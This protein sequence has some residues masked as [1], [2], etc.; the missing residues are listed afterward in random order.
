MDRNTIINDRDQLIEW[1]IEACKPKNKWMVGTEH[2]KFAYTFSKQKKRYIPLEYFGSYGIKTFLTELSKHGWMPIYEEKNIIALKKK[3]QSITLEPGGQI[4]LSGAPLKNLHSTCRETNEH[5]KLLKEVGS[6]LGILLVGLGVRPNETLQEVP[7]MPKARYKIMRGYMPTRGSR[8]L[9]MMHSTCTVQANLDF[10]SEEDMIK[11]TRL[12]V[13]L[14]PVVT[15][16]FANSPFYRGDF[17]GYES[18]RK[19]IWTDTDPDRCG[20]LKIALEDNFSFSQ[21]VNYA[22]SVPMYF[23]VR[24]NNYLNCAGKSF[25]E[26]MRGKLDVIPDEKPTIADWE[27]HLS[28]I[29]TEVR[30]KKIIEVRGADAGNWRRTCALPAFWVGILYGN[31]SINLAEKI[32]ENWT[33][34]DIEQLSVDVAKLGL[35]AEIKK[36][37]VFYIASELLNIARNTLLERG[38]LDS[39]GNDETGYLNV[40]EEILQNKASPARDLINNFSSTYNNNMKKLIEEISY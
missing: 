21:Y 11:K 33:K 10:E 8:G 29:F 40:L 1:F 5:L 13:K 35:G 38:F 27:N 18:L 25:L 24:D 39:A 20:I 4:E 17:N 23:I 28:T 12:A 36:E 14:Q 6:K 16:L 19:H 26:F 34:D 2:E 7:L 32:C 9:E 22:L 3:S 37:K 30:L 15:A 31:N